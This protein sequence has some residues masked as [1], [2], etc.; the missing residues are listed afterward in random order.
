MPATYPK[1]PRYFAHRFMRVLIKSCAAQEI[2]QDGLALLTVVAM[3]ED[4]KRYSDAVTFWNEQLGP[5]AG[6]RNWDQLNRTRTRVIAAGWLHYEPGGRGKVGRYWVTIP[7]HLEVLDDQPVGEDDP[8]KIRALFPVGADQSLRETRIECGSNTEQNTDDPL[9]AC[10]QS[11]EPSNLSLCPIPDPTPRRAATEPIIDPSE[12]DIT[13]QADVPRADVPR[14]TENDRVQIVAGKITSQA[15]PIQGLGV[16]IR[17]RARDA[18]RQNENIAVLYNLVKQ[19]T[20]PLVQRIAERL[21]RD[22]APDRDRK[23][24]DK[25]WVDELLPA[26]LA[27]GSGA[28]APGSTTTANPPN[29]A[30]LPEIVTQAHALLAKHGAAACRTALGW[31]QTVAPSDAAMRTALERE[32]LAAELVEV[33]THG[34]LVVITT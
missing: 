16:W 5:L 13:S 33:F 11:A 1:R 22:G 4:S 18:D 29:H 27:A 20:A 28:Q 21:Q 31:A 8:H 26:I 25:V 9:T 15:D 12:Q 34:P 2:G 24:G 14:G 19:F 3:T 7:D 10:G 32:A 17:W 23:P 30:A 6:F